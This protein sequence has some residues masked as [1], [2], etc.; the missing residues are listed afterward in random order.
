MQQTFLLHSKNFNTER[1]KT[2]KLLPKH[3]KMRQNLH[4]NA[5]KPRQNAP[6]FISKICYCA[7]KKITGIV[8]ITT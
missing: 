5:S 4:Q 8:R 6:K 3:A 1:Q 2:P 7:L